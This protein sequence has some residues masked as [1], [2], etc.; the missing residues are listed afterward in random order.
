MRF[1]AV[2][3]GGHVVPLGVVEVLVP[4]GEQRAGVAYDAV[5][6]VGSSQRDATLFWTRTGEELHPLAGFPLSVRN[7]GLTAR[8]L[9]AEVVDGHVVAP[10]QG[11]CTKVG[12]EVGRHV[13]VTIVPDGEESLVPPCRWYGV[14]VLS[15]LVL[16]GLA[17]LLYAHVSAR[18]AKRH[19]VGVDGSPL[20][21][22]EH[23]LVAPFVR[24]VL[25]GVGSRRVT[26]PEVR[27]RRWETAQ[28]SVDDGVVA[29]AFEVKLRESLYALI[30][31]G[32]LQFY[33]IPGVL[34]ELHPR[35]YGETQILSSRT[36][37]CH[38]VLEQYLVRVALLDT[39][40]ER[41]VVIDFRDQQSRSGNAV[42]RDAQAIDK[43]D[44]VVGFEGC[45]SL[46]LAE[47]GIAPLYL[48]VVAVAVDDVRSVESKG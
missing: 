41:H 44:A 1:A 31:F 38:A 4:R 10:C 25:R 13:G 46:R 26:E 9:V 17:G 11:S 48:T 35:Y 22:H 7:H 42:A 33:A 34:R 20:L 5:G 47:A 21:R 40:V 32:S 14:G 15:V 28:V 29:I 23:F 6:A 16:H 24:L 43:G 27:G 30:A 37:C 36:G 45:G 19:E 39:D 2:A 18:D 8:S 3:D 12:G